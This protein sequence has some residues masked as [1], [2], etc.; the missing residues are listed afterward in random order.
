MDPQNL[1]LQHSLRKDLKDPM[2]KL[3]KG[4]IEETIILLR[5][6]LEG[7]KALIVGVGDVTAEILVNNNFQP[8][9]IITDGYTKRK[10]LKVWVDYP[11]YD[12]IRTNSPAAVITKHAWETIII[13]IRQL[14]EKSNKIHIKVDGEEDLLVLPLIVELPIG[15]IVIYGQP[16]EGAVV[17]LVDNESKENATMLLGRME[18]I[19]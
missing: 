9:M 15:S 2:G 18:I 11:K 17:R 8:D 7:F 5:K 16:N 19:D 14:T 12:E 13:A 1:H 4:S 6:E 10:K 3:L